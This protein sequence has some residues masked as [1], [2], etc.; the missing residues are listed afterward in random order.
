MNKRIEG[1]GSRERRGR[2]ISDLERKCG[3]NPLKRFGKMC[4]EVGPADR[5]V[6]VLG[7]SD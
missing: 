2:D 6:G 4:T 1:G 3:N 7:R 5:G